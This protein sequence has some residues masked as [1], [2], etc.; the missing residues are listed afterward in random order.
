M[1]GKHSGSV[2]VRQTGEKWSASLIEV[3]VEVADTT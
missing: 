3:R 1:L 2:R